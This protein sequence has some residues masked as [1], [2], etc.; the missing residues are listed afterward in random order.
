MTVRTG[1]P[2]A[3]RLGPEANPAQMPLLDPGLVPRPVRLSYP[4]RRALIGRTSRN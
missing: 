1:Q 4:D 2:A 3:K